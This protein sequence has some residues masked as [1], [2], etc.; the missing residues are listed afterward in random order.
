MK[1]TKQ[2]AHPDMNLTALEEHCSDFEAA[3]GMSKEAWDK[4]PGWKKAG[5]RKSMKLF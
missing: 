2:Y 1:A 5:V 4:L 3:F